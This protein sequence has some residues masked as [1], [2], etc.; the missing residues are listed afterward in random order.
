M[1]NFVKQL[2]NDVDSAIESRCNTTRAMCGLDMRTG[3][4]KCYSEICLVRC[5]VRPFLAET[6]IGEADKKYREVAMEAAK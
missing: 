1:S 6:T 2:L 5:K 4:E 3:E